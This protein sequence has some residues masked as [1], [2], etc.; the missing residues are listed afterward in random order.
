MRSETRDPRV[1][2]V[3]RSGLCTMTL[4]RCRG[5]WL[6]TSWLCVIC[7]YVTIRLCVIFSYELALPQE[8]VHVIDDVRPAAE[9]GVIVARQ[10]TDAAA[11]AAAVGGPSVNCR[12]DERRIELPADITARCS[13]TSHDLPCDQI[14]CDALLRTPLR[15][16]PDDAMTAYTAWRRTTPV[17]DAD[18]AQ[19]A[20]DCAEFRRSRGFHRNAAAS[21]SSS[22][23]SGGGVSDDDFAL[24]FNIL[25]HRDADQVYICRRCKKTFIKYF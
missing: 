13:N 3:R 21:S 1:R 23:H 24:A 7:F 2:S 12:E 10:P 18:V 19:Q 22:A 8:D 20:G 16:L 17:R 4:V 6:Y 15:V 9:V 14:N 25:A 5:W 11:A